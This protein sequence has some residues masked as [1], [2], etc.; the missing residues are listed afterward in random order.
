[1]IPHIEASAKPR[2]EHCV[3]FE[4]CQWIDTHRQTKYKRK[5]TRYQNLTKYSFGLENYKVYN[6]HHEK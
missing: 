4:S 1:M 6:Y 2:L 3:L 5:L